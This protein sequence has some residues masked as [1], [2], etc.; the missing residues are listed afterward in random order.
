MINLIK[1]YTLDQWLLLF[2]QVVA[3]L[4]IIP[5]IMYG[6]WYH[7][8]IAFFVYFIGL[9][10][11]PNRAPF[12][13]PEAESELVSGYHTEYSGIRF[14]FFALAEYVEVFVLCGV[15]VALFLGGYL[16]PFDLGKETPLGHL[17]QLG[18]FF[19]KTL[20]L[21]YVVI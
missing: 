4:A 16:V 10:A 9:L 1:K 14:G 6:S 7:W 5:M 12:D 15:A 8:L 13:L 17:F 11:E 18:S 21:Y 19:S 3:H 2:S 20:L